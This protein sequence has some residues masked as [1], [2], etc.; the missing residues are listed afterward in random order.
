[1]GTEHNGGQPQ[2]AV[3]L[4]EA[5]RTMEAGGIPHPKAY[6]MTLLQTA[7][8]LR[9]AG[10]PALGATFCERAWEYTESVPALNHDREVALHVYD[11][12]W[13]SRRPRDPYYLICAFPLAVEEFGPGSSWVPY[14][15]QELCGYVLETAERG[16]FGS[17]GDGE[18]PARV[19]QLALEALVSFPAA[20]DERSWRARTAVAGSA[21][22][23]LFYAGNEQWR[24]ALQE[25]LAGPI[26]GHETGS[27]LVDFLFALQAWAPARAA[28]ERTLAAVE[29]DPGSAGWQKA[30]ALLDLAYGITMAPDDAGTVHL[31]ELEQRAGDLAF[32][33][34]NEREAHLL[35]EKLTRY[36]LRRLEENPGAQDAQQAMFD[37]LKFDPLTAGSDA[38]R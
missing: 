36:V 28:A 27:G 23:L 26:D 32:G 33:S 1:M 30:G 9:A 22:R 34:F 15:L 20:A 11:A 24:A 8:A 10:D 37:R 13:D 21:A 18:L 3:Q 12:G 5:V 25:W 19:Q 7:K 35:Q 2:A 31:P 29:A 4:I 14:L 16:R 6:V 17:L 38:A